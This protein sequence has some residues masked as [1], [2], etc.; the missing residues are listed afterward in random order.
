MAQGATQQIRELIELN[1]ARA[2][3]FA[4]REAQPQGAGWPEAL[5]QP[6]ILETGGRSGVGY[7]TDD[8]GRAMLLMHDPQAPGEVMV[9]DAAQLRAE[10]DAIAT[11]L[12]KE[13]KQAQPRDIYHGVDVGAGSSESLVRIKGGDLDGEVR[14]KVILGDDGKI[15]ALGDVKLGDGRIVYLA[16]PHLN[17]GDALPEQGRV[18][19]GD[20]PDYDAYRH[21]FRDNPEAG[22][23]YRSL[24]DYDSAIIYQNAGVAV[25]QNVSDA[26][27]AGL[28][29]RV[30]D[31]EVEAQS[32]QDTAPVVPEEVEDK[33]AEVYILPEVTRKA[34]R[35]GPAG[36]AGDFMQKIG[37]AERHM[38]KLGPLDREQS[39]Q[40]RVMLSRLEQELRNSPDLSDP[41]VQRQVEF[42]FNNPH[43]IAD[44]YKAVAAQF[45]QDRLKAGGPVDMTRYGDALK[46]LG[47]GDVEQA[48]GA[49]RGDVPESAQDQRLGKVEAFRENAETLAQNEIAKVPG[50]P[51][52]MPVSPV[53]GLG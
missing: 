37:T 35:P 48:K 39:S 22:A 11:P 18:L 5:P 52:P 36:G 44:E 43:G 6:V 51:T 38:D 16:D 45:V 24:M 12:V 40:A 30:Q 17:I 34:V 42:M 53:V 4:V 13:L 33:P 14:R 8:Q 1:G 25:Q 20:V 31:G 47:K 49:L 7:I 2:P 10:Y 15:S 50:A 29:I 21:S 27:L 26:Q 19:K 41:K 46:A 23:L 32:V 28:S 9:Y 3:D